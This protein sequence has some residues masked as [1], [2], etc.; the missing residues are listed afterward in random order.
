[1]PSENAGRLRATDNSNYSTPTFSVREA[2]ARKARSLT[3]R[4]KDQPFYLDNDRFRDSWRYNA[5][6]PAKGQ[7][8]WWR[9]HYSTDQL[10]NTDYPAWEFP[11]F[12][13]S[14]GFR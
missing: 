6:I 3:P 8:V 13:R 1:M 9:R 14:D 12:A 5:E 4:T 11:R 10:S 2:A 7:H